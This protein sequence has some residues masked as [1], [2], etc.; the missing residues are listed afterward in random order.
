MCKWSPLSQ[1]ER[2]VERRCE[3]VGSWVYWQEGLG[4]RWVPASAGLDGWEWR[5]GRTGE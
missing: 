5:F 3:G 1:D 2:G 4:L